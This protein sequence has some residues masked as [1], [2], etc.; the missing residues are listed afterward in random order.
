MIGPNIQALDSNPNTL[1]L[2]HCTEGSHMNVQ[3]NDI[4][5]YDTGL[6]LARLVGQDA[7]TSL[8]AR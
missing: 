7:G 8:E 4:I 3:L 1:V 5:T 2:E 6:A